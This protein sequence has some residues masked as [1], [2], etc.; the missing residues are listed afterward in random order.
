MADFVCIDQHG[1][2]III[3]KVTSLLDLQTID[4]YVKNVNNI[5]SN[6]ILA[7]WLP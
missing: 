2:I 7:S 6:N 4:N 3:S 5:D 1:I